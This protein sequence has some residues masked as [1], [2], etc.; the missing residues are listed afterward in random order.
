MT[1]Q[2]I[3]M[4]FAVNGKY[5]EQ[6]SFPMLRD[7]L[8]SLSPELGAKI[9]MLDYKDPTVALLL[10]LLPLVVLVNGVDRMYLGQIGLG[11]LKF[12]TLGGLFIGFSSWDPP[13]D[14]TFPCYWSRWGILRCDLLR[15]TENKTILL[16]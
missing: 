2:Q 4:F 10:S 16:P 13:A 14:A 5:F 8:S 3:Q 12:F 6:A 9:Y 1:E 7:I 15:T 11:L